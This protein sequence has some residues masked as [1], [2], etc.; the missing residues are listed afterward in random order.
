MLETNTW[1][2][3]VPYLLDLGTDSHALLL[4]VH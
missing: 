1:L 2:N 4:T 3:S